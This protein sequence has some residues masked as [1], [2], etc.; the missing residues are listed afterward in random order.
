MLQT[1]L[2][3]MESLSKTE[4][5]IFL[6]VVC[7]LIPKAIFLTFILQ[8]KVLQA[9]SMLHRPVSGKKKK[10]KKAKPVYDISLFASTCPDSGLY[11]LPLNS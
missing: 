1:S 9:M 11:F 2:L 3:L 7:S 10:K 5:P 6:S 4:T 8:Q